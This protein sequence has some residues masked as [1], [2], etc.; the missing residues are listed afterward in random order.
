MLSTRDSIQGDR[1]KQI[2]SEGMEKYFIQMEMTR[3]QE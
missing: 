3:V 1:H 2:K